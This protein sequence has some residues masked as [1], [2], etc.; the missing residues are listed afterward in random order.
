MKEEYRDALGISLLDTIVQDVRYAVRTMRG[1]PGFT[2]VAVLSLALGLGANTAIFSL[3]DAL[4]LR[5][6]PVHN[7]QELAQLKLSTPGARRPGGPA[8]PLEFENLAFAGFGLE[9]EIRMDHS[10]LVITRASENRDVAQQFW[11]Q[12]YGTV[13]T[14]LAVLYGC[15]RKR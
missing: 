1:N 15:T 10:N 11:T 12:A 7:P 4:M 3:T 14:W 2:V 8:A 5:W 13:R 9:V 6:L